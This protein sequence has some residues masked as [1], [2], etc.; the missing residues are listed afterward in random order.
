[1]KKEEIK[2]EITKIIYQNSHDDSESLRIEFNKIQSVIDK[3]V[4]ISESH[5]QQVA[6]EAAADHLVKL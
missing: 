2:Q 6:K 1:M 3:I 5:A 4:S